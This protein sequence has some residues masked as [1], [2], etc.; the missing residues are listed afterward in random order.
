M[1]KKFKGLREETSFWNQLPD[2]HCRLFFIQQSLLNNPKRTSISHIQ[3]G[4]LCKKHF[5][6]MKLQ[7]TT[8]EK[9]SILKL[10]QKHQD[11]INN[12]SSIYRNYF[13]LN[14][15]QGDAFSP[16][17]RSLA[18]LQTSLLNKLIQ[19]SLNHKSRIFHFTCL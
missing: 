1:I 4:N 2:K 8:E 12:S 17:K 6:S 16:N 11:K 7:F 14:F 10:W 9:N 15:Q 19:R 3:N 13:S 18:C 5:W